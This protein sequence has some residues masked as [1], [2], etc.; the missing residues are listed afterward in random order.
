MISE[1]GDFFVTPPPHLRTQTTLQ[2]RFGETL[3]VMLLPLTAAV[4]AYGARAVL[5]V[6]APRDG[7]V[8]VFIENNTIKIRLCIIR[9]P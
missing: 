4:H 8:R 2:I 9:S 6:L 5:T 7:H 3:V 1:R